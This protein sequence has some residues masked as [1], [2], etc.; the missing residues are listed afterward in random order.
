MQNQLGGEQTQGQ[1][2][3]INQ[4]IQ[5]YTNAQN[6]PM[7]QLTNLMNLGRATPTQTTTTQYQAPPS[8]ISQL[9]G[10]GTAAY[11]LSKIAKG[12]RIK[13]Y[14]NGGLVAL[15]MHQAMKGSL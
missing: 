15:A 8:A 13:G 1:Q 3:I 5:N 4:A 9:A 6:Y 10:A 2:Q 11:G 7:Q 12:G 14:K